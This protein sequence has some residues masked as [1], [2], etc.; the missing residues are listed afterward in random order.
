VRKGEAA[1]PRQI[2]PIKTKV[3]IPG[4]DTGFNP[5]SSFD[6][7]I[8]KALGKSPETGEG[9]DM[10]DGAQFGEAPATPAP[11][12]R[13]GPD[14]KFLKSGEAETGEAPPA[15]EAPA[16]EPPVETPPLPPDAVEDQEGEDAE[17]EETV[18]TLRAKHK[19][20][21][22]KYKSLQGMFK[23]I[24]LREQTAIR[25]QHGAAKSAVAWKA[26]AESLQAEL[27][28]LKQGR[29]GDTSPASGGREPADAA[30][31]SSAPHRLEEIVKAI[32]WNMYGSVKEQGDDAVAVWLASNILKI[33]DADRQKDIES[34]R[35]D[36]TDMRRRL[37]EEPT[38]RQEIANH[39]TEVFSRVADI[40]DES[41]E[42][43]FPELFDEAEAGAVGKLWVE[44]GKDPNDL[45]TPRGVVDSILW[46]RFINNKAPRPVSTPPAAPE[47][48]EEQESD[49]V[50]NTGSTF[51]APNAR[52]TRAL[53]GSR[54]S[55]PMRSPVSSA[56]RGDLASQIKNAM[57]ASAE[58]DD[59]FGFPTAKSAR[60]K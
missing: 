5:V 18:E 13:R 26:K 57:R 31:D 54:S 34:L 56:V 50:D 59:L 40:K 8:A 38:Q 1:L 32:D 53:V 35:T 17:G 51:P 49:E 10:G 43:A 39:A 28:Q 25:E 6:S 55:A 36:T 41:G 23:P 60:R 19:E 24:Q 21:E 11:A 45:L 33:V 20:I 52:P 44:S 46:Y 47:G 22:Q 27:E 29:G 3:Q 4:V 30:R 42:P 37:I 2:K 9:M 58:T 12:A 16:G 7:K 14:G 48:D 15:E